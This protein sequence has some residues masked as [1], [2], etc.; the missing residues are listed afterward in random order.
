MVSATVRAA[1][2]ILQARAD[3]R[4]VP[5]DA[6]PE[7]AREGARAKKAGVRARVDSPGNYKN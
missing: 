4:V 3:A 6:G 1:K 7:W 2:E 5:E